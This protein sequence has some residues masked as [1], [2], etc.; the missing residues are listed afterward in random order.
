MG[1]LRVELEV[2]VNLLPRI[3][4][5]FLFEA[6]DVLSASVDETGG[7]ILGSAEQRDQ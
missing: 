7:I 5:F 3:D 2:E 4:P 1:V 6:V